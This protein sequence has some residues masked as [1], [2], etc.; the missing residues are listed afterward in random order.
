[1][2]KYMQ[3]KVYWKLCAIGTFLMLFIGIGSIAAQNTR[4]TLADELQSN[5]N[6]ETFVA[7]LETVG[8]ET[9]LGESNT[10]FTVF[11]PSN[12]AFAQLPDYLLAYLNDNLDL[13]ERILLYHIVVGR[14]TVDQVLAET[15]L[16]S[17]E[18]G[19]VEV[20]SDLLRVNGADIVDTDV[21]VFNGV[22]HT[23]DSIMF[24]EISLPPVDPFV[25]FDPILTAGSS[26]VRPVTDR[27]AELFEREGFSGDIS[28]EE[29]GTNVGIE[30]FCVNS[31]TDIANASRPIRDTEIEACIANDRTPISFFV[32][33]DALAITISRE[34]DF[35]DNL[36]LEQLAQ[37]FVGDVTT[38]DEINPNW[39]IQPIETFSPGA[40]SGTFVYFVSAVIAAGLGIESD[41][42][43]ARLLNAT[44]VRFSEDD[45]VLV[46]GVEG[47]AY[48][49]GYFGFAYF[50]ANE[51]RLRVV[52]IEGITP[53]ESTAESGEY[54]LSRPLFI[55]SSASVMNAKPQVA[56]FIK[57]YINNVRYELGTE[58]DQ[59]GYFP[60]NRD[61]LNLDRLEW[62]AA[63]S[64]AAR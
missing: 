62:L 36:T 46:Q 16:P 40:D 61:V 30:R 32:A 25:N 2:E 10:P 12:E 9:L 15:T 27:M 22:I 63:I 29:N 33:L 19:L 41:E 48:A 49:I 24:P 3:T 45:N 39:P 4:V 11:V 59:I 26:T 37:I 8:L 51:S 60:V 5:S 56:E 57:Y 34:N 6:Y 1:M 28:V 21:L 55:Y 44:N 53:N 58:A 47:S 17:L 38:W 23:I 43:E 52:N 20:S 35:V 18:G 13:L 64:A 42:A 31:E 14:F 7:L 50:N 54:A